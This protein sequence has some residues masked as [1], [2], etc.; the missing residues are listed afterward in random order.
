MPL[1]YGNPVILILGTKYMEKE[2]P[3]GRLL[4]FF[5]MEGIKG[6]KCGGG[7]CQPLSLLAQLWAAGPWATLS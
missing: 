2:T 5:P 6:V 1:I 7:A 3:A 4:S